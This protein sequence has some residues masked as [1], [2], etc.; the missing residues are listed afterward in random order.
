MATIKELADKYFTA[1]SRIRQHLH[2]YPELSGEEYETSR[3]IQ[4]ELDKLGIEHEVVY[5][6]GVVGLIR[7]GKPGK[8]V[9]LRADMDALPIEETADVPYRS[10][11]PGRMHACGHD[12]H[13]AGLLGAAMILNELKSE[14]C[15][16]V[17]LM[18]QPD[19]ELN[20]GA[21]PM[22]EAGILENPTVSAAFGLHLWGPMPVGKVYYKDGP[23]M[24]AADAF[25]ITIKGRGCHAA[26]PQ[27]GIDPVVIAAS[28]ITE[29]QNIVS[30]KIDP[31]KPA[32]ISTCSIHGGD[33]FN[34]IPQEVELKGTV[35]TLHEQVRSQIPDLMEQ[36]LKGQAEASGCDYEFN[37]KRG[38]P[39]VVNHKAPNQVAVSAF[40]KIVGSENVMELEDPNMGGEDFAY[41]GQRVPSAFLYVGIAEADKPV[42]IHHH[43]EF[44]WQDDVL[45]VSSAG[46]AQIA[47]DFLN[48]R[49]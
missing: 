2:Q 7:G 29:F 15:G 9:L 42:P 23:M 11:N 3:F 40:S 6:T 20:G 17:K 41:L 10:K 14:L 19:E 45:K 16:N 12:G 43:P 31:L 21:L 46:L 18:F 39:A 4:A 24:A 28:T 37:Y 38:Y 49:G 27:V 5:K 26:M 1:Y 35:R 8:T 33:A 13:T 44:Q 32:V 22:I 30:R 48:E 47:V 34:V 36:V 25:T